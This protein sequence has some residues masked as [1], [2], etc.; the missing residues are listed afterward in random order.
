MTE[1]IVPTDE[2]G[3]LA[4]VSVLKQ[5]G[6]IA[7]PTETVYGIGADIRQPEAVHRLFLIKGRSF[8]QPL[9][10]HCASFEQ[11][12]P[13]VCNVPQTARLIAEKFLPGPI[14]LILFRSALVPD[15]ITSG[16]ETVGIRVVDHP[17]F[18]RIAALL[19]APLA[20]TSA[21]LSGEPATN[22]FSRISPVVL[23]Q[24]NLAVNAG[25]SGSGIA[26]TLID[27]T[28]SPPRLLRTGK[29]GKMEIEKTLGIEI[30]VGEN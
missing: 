3:L 1:K 7:F 8:R 6:V 9:L 4:A 30:T 28:V 5:G 18:T 19:G 10:L 27:L 17:A 12:L 15:I 16:G 21:N 23:N 22:D 11:A 14:A 25:I 13:F 20:G 29:I 26:S 24:V 2:T